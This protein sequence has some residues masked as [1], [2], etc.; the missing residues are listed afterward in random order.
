MELLLIDALTQ[1]QEIAIVLTVVK[2]TEL[3]RDHTPAGGDDSWEL[4][5]GS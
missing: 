5:E 1:Q 2:R 4:E 3:D